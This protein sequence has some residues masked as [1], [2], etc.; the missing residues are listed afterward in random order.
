VL[1]IEDTDRVRLLTL[2]RPDALNAINEALYDALTEALIAARHDP[3]V[4]VVVLTGK[5]RAFSAG[6]DLLEMA[7]RKTGTTEPGRHGFPGL[8]D[9]LTDF[10]KPFICAVNGL[11]IGIGATIVGLADLVLMSSEARLKCPFSSLG[12]A[13]EAAS[14][15]T[16]P[17]LLGRQQATWTLMSAE[18]LTADECLQIGLVWKVCPPDQLLAIT[19]DRARVLAS[20]PIASLIEIKRTIVEPMREQIRAARQRENDAFTRLLGSPANIEAL[21]AFAEKREPDFAAVDAAT[22]AATSAGS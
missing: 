4:A 2:D 9:E 14:S 18:W 16:F 15:V 7:G 3:G 22:A 21:T 10:P 20:K 12:V 8:I 11:G 6:T 13:P 5:G 1:H 19:L 17:A